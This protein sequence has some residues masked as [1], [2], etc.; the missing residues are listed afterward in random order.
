MVLNKQKKLTP[1]NY[2]QADTVGKAYFQF[3]C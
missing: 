3:N 2:T 1:A